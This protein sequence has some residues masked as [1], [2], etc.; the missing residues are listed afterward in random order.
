[1][2]KIS[3]EAIYMK[4]L[5]ARERSIKNVPLT[6]R[7]GLLQGLIEV[8]KDNSG[9]EEFLIKELLNP[10]LEEVDKLRQRDIENYMMLEEIKGMIESLSDTNS[11]L[12]EM[13]NLANNYIEVFNG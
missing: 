4:E 9:I 12:K 2:G 7:K 11:T 10:L 13:L 6:D 8:S 3:V 5:E 1:L